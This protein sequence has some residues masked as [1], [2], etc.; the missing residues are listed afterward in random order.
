MAISQNDPIKATEVAAALD[1]KVNTSDVLTLAEIQA[2]TDLTGKVASASVIKDSAL[3][4]KY[5]PTAKYI[6]FGKLVVV[7]FNAAISDDVYTGLP[8]PVDY[9]TVV[10]FRD[11]NNGK[12]A[13]F[14]MDSE[15]VIKTYLATNYTPGNIYSGAFAYI[16]G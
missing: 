13:S 7:K 6:Q 11:E 9:S 4:I 8:K 3:T 12:F 10:T 16:A 15:A 14:Y 2:I 1:K 5:V